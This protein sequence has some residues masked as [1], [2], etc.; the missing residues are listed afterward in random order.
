MQLTAGCTSGENTVGGVLRELVGNGRI[1]SQ[2]N[3]TDQRVVDRGWSSVISGSLREKGKVSTNEEQQGRKKTPFGTHVRRSP[4]LHK[5]RHPQ[6][7]PLPA[8][9][10]CGQ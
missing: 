1:D 10:P 2:E 5:D 6:G 3:A 4:L 9:R 8:Q 7:R